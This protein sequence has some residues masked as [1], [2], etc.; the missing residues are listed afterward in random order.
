MNGPTMRR[1]ENGSTRPTSKPPRSRCRLSM[2]RS[3]ISAFPEYSL[4][5]RGFHRLVQA[6][7]PEG[8]VLHGAVDEKSGRGPHAALRA[9]VDVLV[10][11]L[12]VNV[13][14]HLVVVPVQVQ[15]RLQR[16]LPQAVGLQVLLMLEEQVVHRPELVLRA[17]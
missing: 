6:F 8:H 12:Q 1:F 5:E 4:P 15:L 2:T 7:Q 10:H 9:A 14:L 3:S 17:R 11:P 16:V 13:L